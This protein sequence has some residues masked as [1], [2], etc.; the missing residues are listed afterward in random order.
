MHGTFPTGP[1]VYKNAIL[2]SSSCKSCSFQRIAECKRA[3][4]IPKVVGLVGKIGTITRTKI[5]TMVS[6]VN[7]QFR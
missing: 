2:E 4:E 6:D 7:Q 5:A 1:I 3:L